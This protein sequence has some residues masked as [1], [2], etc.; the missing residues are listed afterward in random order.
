MF[1]PLALTT[2]LAAILSVASVAQAQPK[3]AEPDYTLTGNVSLLS[4]YRYRGISQTRTKPALQGTIDFAHKSGLYLG[5]FGSNVKWLSDVG[6]KGNIEVDLYGGY[7]GTIVGDLGYDVGLLQYLYPRN[8]L[9]SLGAAN[10]NTLEAYGGLTY[11]T[12]SAKYYSSLTNLFGNVNSKR[13]GYLDISATQDLGDGWSANAHVG[14]QTI[15]N[16]GQLN[17]TDYK[18]GV[19]KDLSGFIFGAAIVGTNADKALYTV[20]GKELGK[21]MLVLSG[22]KNF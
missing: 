5:A 4:D 1:K 7:K 3:A 19:T 22:G 9:A 11:K 6:S 10:A 18:I 20:K 21:P 13:S 2:L 15:R 14:R 8:N 17:Y 16:A 12:I